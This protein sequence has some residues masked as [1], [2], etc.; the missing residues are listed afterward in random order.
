MRSATYFFQCDPGAVKPRGV[1]AV[2]TPPGSLHYNITIAAAGGCVITPK[3]LS[4][5]WLSI[6]L[7]GVVAVAYF[8]GGSAYNAKVRGEEG[9]DMIPQWHLWQQL[10]GLVKDGCIFSWKHGR[11]AAYNAPR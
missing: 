11:V 9:M 5:G 10:P 3:P 6:I 2:E 7:T 4:L 8:G 1:S